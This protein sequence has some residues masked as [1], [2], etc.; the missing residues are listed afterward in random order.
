LPRVQLPFSPTRQRH[1][2]SRLRERPQFWQEL[3]GALR[4]RGRWAKEHR[5]PTLDQAL[6][7]SMFARLVE[8]AYGPKPADDAGSGRLKERFSHRRSDMHDETKFDH[9]Q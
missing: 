4:G 8:G 1:F 3:E 2:R 7:A 5:F 6:R 9:L